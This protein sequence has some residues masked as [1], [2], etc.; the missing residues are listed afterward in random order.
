MLESGLI[1][2]PLGTEG[3]KATLLPTDA[4]AGI[5]HT[6]NFRVAIPIGIGARFRLN[7]VL[8]FSFE[9]G[10]RYLFTDYIDDVSKN[11]V[12]LGVFGNNELQRQCRTEPMRLLHRH[13]TY[14]GR[15]GETYYC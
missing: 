12:D 5:Q 8:D 10:F 14:T 6:K 13:Y 15:D 9:F 1:L 3:Q 7:E 2:Q 11:Y 4:N